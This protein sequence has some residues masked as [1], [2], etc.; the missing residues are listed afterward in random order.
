MQ[1][2]RK[3]QNWSTVASKRKKIDIGFWNISAIYFERPKT[4]RATEKSLEIIQ[5][6]AILGQKSKEHLSVVKYLAFISKL[7]LFQDFLVQE[8]ILLCFF[9]AFPL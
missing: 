5:D 2:R 7:R 8:A 4:L 1:L 9:S 6:F 3:Q